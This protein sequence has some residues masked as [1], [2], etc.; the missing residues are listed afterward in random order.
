VSSSNPHGQSGQI[1]I[2]ALVFCAILGAALYSLYNVIQLSSAKQR[3]NDAADTAAYSGATVIAQGLNYT[4]YTNRAML[5]NNAMIGQ[6]VSLRSTLGM[7]HWY[8]KNQEKTWRV[9]QALTSFIPYV[10]PVASKVSEYIVK[11]ADFWGDKLLFGARRLAE[12]LSVTGTTAIGLT[13]QVMWVAQQVQLTESLTTFEPIMLKVAKANAPGAKVDPVMHATAFG[14]LTTWGMAAYQL[15][16]K[17]RKNHRTLGTNEADKDLYLQFVAESNKNGTSIPYTASRNLLPNG[18]GLWMATGC[19]TPAVEG[20]FSPM[21]MDQA[22]FGTAMDS[23][24]YAL[25]Q[26]GALL[27][28]IANLYMCM[29]HRHGGAEMVQLK[30]GSLAWTAVDAMSINV[31]LLSF[32]IGS[33]LPFA[34]GAVTSFVDEGDVKGTAHSVRYMVDKI[35]SE[36][37]NQG[38]KQKYMGHKTAQEADC[39]EYLLPAWNWYTVSTTTRNDGRCAVLAG[40]TDTSI[41]KRGLWGSG[42]ADTADRV[43]ESEYWTPYKQHWL[44]LPVFE[45]KLKTSL[46]L[47]NPPQAGG[48][49]NGA[50]NMMPAGVTDQTGT[51][52]TGLPNTSA[53]VLAGSNFRS[54]MSGLSRN[55]RSSLPGLGST[56]VPRNYSLSS[57]E[58]ILI[59]SLTNGDTSGVGNDGD[60]P[61]WFRRLLIKALGIQPVLELMTLQVSDGVEGPRSRRL[62][63]LFRLLNDGLPKWFWDI[64]VQKETVGRKA[65]DIYNLEV[66]DDDHQDYHPRRYGLGPLVYAPL[67]LDNKKI[68][69]TQNLS[70]GGAMTGLPDY[71]AATRPGLRAIGKARVFY[72]QPNDHWLTRYKTVALPNLILP[73]WQARNEGLS[74]ADKWGLLLLDGVS[75]WL[76]S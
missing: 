71:E 14:P 66:T 17:V 23:A 24:I 31:P 73:Y 9:I 67:I 53:L 41:E 52:V 16:P 33:D 60:G 43:I 20:A 29:Y 11:F 76:G 21:F 12:Y 69:T 63:R 27:G 45:Q 3:L 56:L 39:V 30:D 19:D 7:S 35:K 34:G 61:G 51:A 70:I 64:R 62:N 1:L 65:T 40:G 28:P 13:N 59:N 6:M 48:E 75:N 22:G 10:G 74:Y 15:Q 26:M 57:L 38:G 46:D 5:A 8:W 50:G 54:G 25:R 32:V 44:T 4:A 37:L 47:A 42:L 58:T 72:R 36:S 2:V 68:K 18:V 49:P 55:M